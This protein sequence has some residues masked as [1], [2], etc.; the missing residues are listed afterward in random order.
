MTSI[1]IGEGDYLDNINFTLEFMCYRGI[2][3]LF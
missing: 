3:T 2:V 1:N